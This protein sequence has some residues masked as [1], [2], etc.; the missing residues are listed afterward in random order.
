MSV[1]LIKHI[2]CERPGARDLSASA[3]SF[4]LN[5]YYCTV[6]KQ[7]PILNVEY[8]AICRKANS[9]LANELL[10]HPLLLIKDTVPL[11]QTACSQ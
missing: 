3:H 8:I 2:Y 11:R 5:S 10:S 1:A 9:P 4:R 6:F 7:G